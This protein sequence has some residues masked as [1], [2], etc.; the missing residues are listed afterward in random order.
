MVAGYGRADTILMQYRAFGGISKVGAEGVFMAC[1]PEQGIGLAVK[2]DDGADR[3]AHVLGV[4]VLGEIG[5]LNPES[6]AVLHDR[7]MPR[8]TGPD[9]AEIGRIR[10][11]PL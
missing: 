10:V 2:V 11:L 6:V 5:I 9:G 1:I 7:I 4:A 3:A 8:F